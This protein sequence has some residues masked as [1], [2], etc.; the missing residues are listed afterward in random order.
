MYGLPQL[1]SIERI[2]NLP[3]IK[4]G[5]DKASTF[6]VK[7]KVNTFLFDLNFSVF[8]KIMR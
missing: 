4:T 2:A 1:V 8:K 3:I 5:L 6:Y 7:V